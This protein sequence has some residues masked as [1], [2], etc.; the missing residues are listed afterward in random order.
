MEE[1]AK[2]YTK[3]DRNE[4]LR[5]DEFEDAIRELLESESARLDALIQIQTEASHDLSTLLEI[6]IDRRTQFLADLIA[7]RE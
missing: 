2:Y 1:Q 7:L 4:P 5:V 6:E 3:I